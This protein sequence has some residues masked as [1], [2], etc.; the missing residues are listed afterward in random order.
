MPA[1]VVE[2]YRHPVKSMF[3]EDVDMVTV[4]DGGVLGDRARAFEA[5][6]TGQRIT[7]KKYGAMLNCRARYLSAPSE[8]D[9]APPIEVTMP[10][11]SVVRGDSDELIARVSDL[12]GV[13]VRL[14]A[15]ASGSQVDL[16]PV[17]IVAAG[18][19]RWLAA[20]HPSGRW[21]ARRF[22]PN[23]VIDD[24]EDDG[25]AEDRWLGC[26][27]QIG[28]AVL[29]V[30]MPTPRCVMTTRAQHE[31]LP[32]DQ[33]IMRTMTNVRMR[34]VPV[35]G[36]RPSVGVYADVVQPGVVHLGDRVTVEPAA[37]RRGRIAAAD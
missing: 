37:P 32:R 35:F 31:V 12:L 23:I 28:D 8:Q 2:L 34:D 30:A 3:G 18:T 25:V 7:A 15:G 11:G 24:G 9:P 17:H 5:V 6:P 33:K 4:V 1:K 27:L 14:T 36:E 20:H 10:D 29:H 16:A 21:E 19:L 26:D 13:Q 22:R